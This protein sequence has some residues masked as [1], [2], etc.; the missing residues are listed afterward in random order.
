MVK[1]PDWDNPNWT[2]PNAR[3]ARRPPAGLR[4]DELWVLSVFATLLHRHG[5]RKVRQIFAN[6]SREPNKAERKELVKLE[7]L[8]RLD[9]MKPKPNVRRLVRELLAEE[10]IGPG[11]RRFQNKSAALDA[12]IRRWQEQRAAIE[13]RFGSVSPVLTPGEPA[14]FVIH[15]RRS[16]RKK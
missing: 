9:A 2:S 14:K 15:D 12:K 10:G 16:S 1:R 6:Y 5:L 8:R 11:D 13:A 3:A 4:E 7:T